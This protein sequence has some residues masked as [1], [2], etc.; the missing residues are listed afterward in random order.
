MNLIQNIQDNQTSCF[1][2]QNVDENCLLY[3][4]C[5]ALGG[6]VYENGAVISSQNIGLIFKFVSRLESQVED[7]MNS[8]VKRKS[9]INSQILDIFYKLKLISTQLIFNITI[10][11][12]NTNKDNEQIEKDFIDD[13][14]KVHC[15]EFFIKVLRFNLSLKIN[16][17]NDDKCGNKEETFRDK[18]I[19]DDEEFMVNITKTL[20]KALYGLDNLFQAINASVNWIQIKHQKFQLGDILAIVKVNNKI[21]MIFFQIYFL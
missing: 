18:N 21:L 19:F 6:L 8:I 17:N 9:L 15:A 13:Q 5:R 11:K 2:N 20:N 14:H 3:E 10:A 4:L 12:I 7:F 1:M 16:L